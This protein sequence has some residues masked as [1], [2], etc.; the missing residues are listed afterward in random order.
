MF[1]LASE[2]ATVVAH[3]RAR[4]HTLQ[5]V[6]R[7]EQ[8]TRCGYAFALL[9]PTDSRMGPRAAS[10]TS[11]FAAAGTPTQRVVGTST[12]KVFRASTIRVVRTPISALSAQLRFKRRTTSSCRVAE[13]PLSRAAPWRSAARRARKLW[14]VSR[15]RPP[16]GLPRQHPKFPARG[17]SPWGEAR[18]EHAQIIEQYT[19]PP[20]D[21]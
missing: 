2:C 17:R 15:L 18:Q 20:S 4:R 11:L 16:G 13:R 12:F 8:R 19:A 7:P 1:M 21:F 3:S 5:S 6:K 10:L 14:F 9:R